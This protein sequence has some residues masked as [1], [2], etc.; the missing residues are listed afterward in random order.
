MCMASA[1]DPPLPHTNNLVSGL[2]PLDEQV[3]CM[4]DARSRY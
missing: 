1:A 2:K 3:I 4:R